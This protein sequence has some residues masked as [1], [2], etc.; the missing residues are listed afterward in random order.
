MTPL[1]ITAYTA[2]SA[3]GRGLAAMRTAL[4]AGRSGLA[5]CDFEDVERG[6]IGRVA[7]LEDEKLPE[8]FV[9]YDCRNNR[10]AWVG[11]GQDDFLAAAASARDRYG[12]A[13]VAVVLGT[14]TSGILATEHAYRRRDPKTGA[15]PADFDFVRT[16]DLLSVSQYV[17]VAL[18]L[19]GP[20]ITIS[21]ACSSSAQSF[22]RAARLIA[23]GVVDA[24][25]V[26][27]ID[28][29]CQTTLRGFASL[30]LISPDR[31]RPCDVE[32]DGISIGEAA[33]FA[34]LE[35]P[36]ASPGGLRLLGFGASADAHHM[37]APHPGGEG[38]RLAMTAALAD[39]G[40][41]PD[42]IDYVNLHGTGSRIN[43]AAED[44]AL[45]A[46]FGPGKPCSSTK[47]W[48]GHALGAAGILEMAIAAQ[49]LAQGLLPGCLGMRRVDPALRS[50]VL[51]EN[52][53]RPLRTIL[54]NSLG[55]GG[56]NCSLI[57]GMTA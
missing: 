46:V 10:L 57:L 5:P 30:E 36:A 4:E 28:S 49:A 3:L 31:C 7:G 53:R 8:R 6:Y 55:F 12:A 20:A 37:S 19:L 27:G 35:R 29:L 9:R 52:V 13:R 43:D 2:T 14:S 33:G 51:T 11:L 21:T 17:R 24:A 34:I 22:G 39:A 50:E 15:L 23:A 41:G 16:H 47:G 48:T 45:V 40:I 18:G 38:A 56:N 42:Q 1:A 54:S 32:R 25:I 44:A 26:G